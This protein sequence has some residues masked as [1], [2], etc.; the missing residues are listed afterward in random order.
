MEECTTG[1]LRTHKER[2]RGKKQMEM[3]S[4][5]RWGKGPERRAG[6]IVKGEDGACVVN[7]SRVVLK[8]W[9]RML[10]SEKGRKGQ[11]LVTCL[12]SAPDVGQSGGRGVGS[13]VPFHRKRLGYG[14]NDEGAVAGFLM[15]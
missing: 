5:R 14:Q 8:N 4:L 9:G 10:G 2:K 6:Y 13:G 11:Q 12:L 3:P 1:I 7:E 15:C